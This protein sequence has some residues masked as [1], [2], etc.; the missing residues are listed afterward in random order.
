MIRKGGST[1]LVQPSKAASA[2]STAATEGRFH[3]SICWDCNV[4]PPSYDWWSYRHSTAPLAR[5]ISPH[6]KWNMNGT[7]YPLCTTI[8]FGKSF[9]AFAAPGSCD[10]LTWARP[11]CISPMINKYSCFYPEKSISTNYCRCF[12][13]SVKEKQASSSKEQDPVLLSL[14]CNTNVYALMMHSED[15]VTSFSGL[16]FEAKN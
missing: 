3:S 1:A 8:G 11:F 16:C 15:Y 9:A 4:I 13:E 12:L 6:A 7:P 2:G 5:C 14:A 10:L